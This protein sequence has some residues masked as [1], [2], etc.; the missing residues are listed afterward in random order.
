MAHAVSELVAVGCS[1]GVGGSRNRRILRAGSRAV[2]F[3]NAVRRTQFCGVPAVSQW[4]E[5]FAAAWCWRRHCQQWSSR[6]HRTVC[7]RMCDGFYWPISFSASRSKF[8]RDANTCSSSCKSEAKL[9]HF[10]SNGGQIE[11]AVDLTGRAYARLPA[12]FKYR[13]AL[14]QGCTCKPEPWSDAELDRHRA[15]ATNEGATR[16]GPV[17]AAKG[18][19]NPVPA[20]SGSQQSVLV[21][22]ANSNSAEPVS[23]PEPAIVATATKTPSN[24]TAK[25]ATP[26]STPAT[27]EAPPSQVARQRIQASAPLA[28]GQVAQG[29]GGFWSG[30]Q[31]SNFSWP[32]DA[33]VRVR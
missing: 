11:D 23:A 22:D 31:S 7:V 25:S 1:G 28:L 5:P 26:R 2:I 10:P 13:K 17:G 4:P 20:L 33:P 21:S 27:G 29:Q 16:P 12:A 14:V 8:Y 15:Y 3:R 9:F 18:E 19:P 30:G 6:S 32:G 24:R